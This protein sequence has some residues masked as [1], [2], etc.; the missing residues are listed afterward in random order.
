MALTDFERELLINQHGILEHLDQEN[1]DHHRRMIK[2][3][4]RGYVINYS[5]DFDRLYREFSREESTYVMDVLEM[6][7]DMQRAWKAE[8]SPDDIDEKDLLFPGFDGN[9][10]SSQ[11]SYAQFVVEDEGRWG[12][13]RVRDFNSHARTE[14]RYRPMVEAWK[15]RRRPSQH[16]SA[17]EIRAILDTL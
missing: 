1:R 6:Y 17:E 10:E 7:S 15:Q 13:L 12:D 2:V 9:N 14:F 5:D 16:L 11:M 3:Y 8:G 4:E